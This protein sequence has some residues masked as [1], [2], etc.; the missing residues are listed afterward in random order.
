[1]AKVLIIDDDRVL[2]DML[3][4]RVKRL[5]HQS[6]FALTL[7]DGIDMASSREF[8]VVM[9]DV[10]LPDGNGIQ[11]ISRF[12]ELAYSPEII[13]ITG[14]GHP[15]G[16]ELAIKHGA[17]DYIEKPASMEGI[18]L[19]LIRALEY[20]KEKK[21]IEV[22]QT[23]KRDD[24]IGSSPQMKASLDLV[25]QAS[26][27][28]VNVLIQGETGTGKELIARTIHQNSKR[29]SQPFIVVDCGAIPEP[30]VEG[31][32]FGHEKG[33]YT[34]ADKKQIG[35][36]EMADTGT[37]FLDEIGELH[38]SIQKAF[39][40]VIQERQYRPLGSKKEKKSDFRLICA[41]NRHLGAMVKRKEF[42]EDLLYRIQSFSIISP[43]LRDRSE[44]ILDLAMY[45]VMKKSEDSG[46]LTKGF[47]PDFFK[48]INSY[49]WPGNVRELINA[50]DSAMASAG[51]Q[52][53]LYPQHL[54]IKI[55]TQI[56]RSSVDIKENQTLNLESVSSAVLNSGESINSYKDY[57]EELQETGDQLYF[58]KIGE[59]S[60]GD[61]KKACKISGLSRSRL[62]FFLQK[63]QI[64]LSEFK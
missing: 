13:I 33:I 51:E 24:I 17:W 23:L 62:Y 4:Y 40:R 11:A 59:L 49:Q 52:P 48:I 26:G 60:K 36:I 14:S 29:V 25:S 16:A 57:K 31:L 54:P 22:Q 8:D 30:L 46:A 45:F 39:L 1:M 50:I 15:D 21:G 64:S 9:L 32:L 19:P 20:R 5:G 61:V 7:K 41:T 37:L 58:S 12:Q 18:T 43:P 35:L 63:Y 38:L 44:D 27:S 28:D 56:A 42:R 55:R 3:S 6:V 10:Q 34:G 53:I 2:C 47:S